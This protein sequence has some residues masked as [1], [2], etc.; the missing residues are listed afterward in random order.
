L[1][2]IYSRPGIDA[3]SRFD[4][5]RP[6]E[7]LVKYWKKVASTSIKMPGGIVRLDVAAFSA[8]DAK[9]VADATLSLCEDLVNNLN[10]RIN[11]DAVAL[12]ETEFEHAGERLARTLAAEEVVR[13]QSGILETKLAAETTTALIKDLRETLLDQTNGYD[14]ALQ[15]M[16]PDA[17]QMRERKI[18]LDVMAKQIAALEGELTS[19][20]GAVASAQ[21]QTVS[22]A[23]VRFGALRS[24]E[25]ADLQIYQNAAEALEHAR[26]AAEFRIVYFKVFV[27]PSLPEE[28]EYPRRRTDIALV[29]ACSLAAW[30]LL[31]ALASVVRNNMA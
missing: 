27:R 23:M 17:P 16:K 19:A 9:S 6:V 24:E 22:A 8:A 13:N 26:I 14:S 7:R 1:R 2:E 11:R 30:G 20:P 21:G 3:M 5:H 15:S 31:M 10:A 28:P 12:A 4:P 25:Q 18:R 29:A